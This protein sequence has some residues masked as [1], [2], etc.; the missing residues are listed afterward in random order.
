MHQLFRYLQ[1]NPEAELDGRTLVQAVAEEAVR[2]ALANRFLL[3]RGAFDPLIRSLE[4]DG[5]V[6]EEGRLRA[7]LPGNLDLPAADDEVHILLDR[8][9]LTTPM[10]H[11][12]QAIDSHGRGN[13]A[14]ANGQL[15][16]FYES[17]FDEIALLVD[18]NAA[19]HDRRNA[20]AASGKY[21]ASLPEPGSE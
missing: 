16:T 6:I 12:D 20:P 5:F 1:D 15:R 10:G 18:Q 17:L 8:Y 3:E 21:R 11:L 9:A 2:L 13:W 19:E 7:A 4:R 14:A